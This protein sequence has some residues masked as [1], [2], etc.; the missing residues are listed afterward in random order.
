MLNMP[1]NSKTLSNKW[2][3]KGKRQPSIPIKDLSKH[4]GEVAVKENNQKPLLKRNQV[5]GSLSFPENLENI[6]K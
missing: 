4:S 6:R 2:N 5:P 1:N 3:Y